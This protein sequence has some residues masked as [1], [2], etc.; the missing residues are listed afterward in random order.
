MDTDMT[1]RHPSSGCFLFCDWRCGMFG[2]MFGMERER[3]STKAEELLSQIEDLFSEFRLEYLE[4][5]RLVD[6]AEERI[7]ELEADRVYLE[8]ML[9]ERGGR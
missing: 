8:E 2:M 5:S 1:V 4:M 9:E 3:R 7:G 6:D